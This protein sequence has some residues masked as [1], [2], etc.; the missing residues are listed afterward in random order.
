MRGTTS[1]RSEAEIVSCLVRVPSP[2]VS[3][4]ILSLSL[5]TPT[6]R[7]GLNQDLQATSLHSDLRRQTAYT[8]SPEVVSSDFFRH[9][10]DSAPLG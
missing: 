7:D 9:R 5:V 8:D 3:L 6:E 10:Q 4:A 1:L 2:N